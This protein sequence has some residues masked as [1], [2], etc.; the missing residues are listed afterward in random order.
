M[1]QI[2][3]CIDSINAKLNQSVMV[4]NVRY[5]RQDLPNAYAV[6][7]DDSCFTPQ[8]T[9]LDFDRADDTLWVRLNIE[10]Q[11][12]ILGIPTAGD[13]L[14]IMSVFQ[15]P[16]ELYLNG[17]LIMKE[18]TWSDFRTP[19][20]VAYDSFD[21]EGCDVVAVKIKT[22]KSSFCKGRFFFDLFLEKIDDIRMDLYNMKAEL[23]YLE[24][25]GVSKE[26]IDTVI[27]LMK[28]AQ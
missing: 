11:P 5:I 18:D 10:H 23:A 9:A 28:Q 26:E 15:A 7:F 24:T 13:R 16:I 14:R 25:I 1:E 3:R 2:L 6:D 22:S 19:E 8:T 27:E 17:T 21:P 20:V 4:K 12:D